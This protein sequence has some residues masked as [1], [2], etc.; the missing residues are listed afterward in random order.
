MV[1]NILKE[2]SLEDEGE[3]LEFEEFQEE[4][5]KIDLLE[6]YDELRKS[7]A[8]ETLGINN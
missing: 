3:K 7:L 1:K 2:W 4:A 6:G 5:K 8:I